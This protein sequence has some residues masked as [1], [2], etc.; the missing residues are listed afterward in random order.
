MVKEKNFNSL[1]NDKWH[2]EY[3]FTEK[4]K[5]TSEDR[6]KKLVGRWQKIVKQNGK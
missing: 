6:I 1:A 4:D 5:S 2:Q 3:F